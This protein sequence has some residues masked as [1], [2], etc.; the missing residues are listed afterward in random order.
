VI[1]SVLFGLMYVVNLFA[2][3]EG[4]WNGGVLL[5]AAVRVFAG[6]NGG[7]VVEPALHA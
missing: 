4:R 7:G 5:R 6:A 1:A 2:L 3:L